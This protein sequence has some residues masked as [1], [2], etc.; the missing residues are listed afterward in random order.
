MKALCYRG[1]GVIEPAEVPDPTPGP[2]EVLVEVVAAGVCGTDHH[3]VAGELGVP[4]GSIP[5]HET[6]GRVLALGADVAGWATGDGVVCYGQVVCGACPACG[7]GHENRCLRPVGFG[8]ARPG[9]FAEYVAVPATC[10]LPLPRGVDP[11]IGAIAT[12]AIATPYHALT[13]VGRLEPGEKVGIIGAGG[14]G[15][16][17]IAL[18][19]LLGAK[20]IVAVDPSP[21]ARDLALDVGADDVFDPS[22]HERPG[23]ELRRIIDGA[24]AVFEFVGRSQSVETGLEALAPG[25]RLVVVGVGHDRPRLPP[26]IRLVGMELAV[27]GS[28]GSTRDDIATVLGLVERGELDTSQS[29]SRRIG[30]DEAPSLFGTPAG[31]ARSVIEPALSRPTPTGADDD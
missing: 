18:A 10:L 13:A 2:G 5:G 19:R 6:A 3:L 4:E 22:S 28:F 26:V 11:A 25:G 31:P 21:A 23:G 24:D 20:R 27:A 14:L 7:S 30:L 15:L 17:A 29:V 1:P 12:D 9:G 16:H 8:M